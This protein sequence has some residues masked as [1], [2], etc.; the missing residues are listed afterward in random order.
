MAQSVIIKAKQPTSPHRYIP[1]LPAAPTRC[2]RTQSQ[3]VPSPC[4]CLAT[5]PAEAAGSSSRVRFMRDGDGVE[6]DVAAAAVSTAAAAG[7]A[8]DTSDVSSL[9]LVRMIEKHEDSSVEDTKAHRMKATKWQHEQM[10]DTPALAEHCADA[11][12][13][14]A[15]GRRCCEFESG[16]D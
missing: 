15:A 2:T 11:V 3:T 9:A 1:Q 13:L 8:V 5:A 12:L 10:T 16:Y 7:A 4:L 6:A 14:G